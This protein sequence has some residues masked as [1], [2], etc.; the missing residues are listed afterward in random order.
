ME[1]K[2]ED[3]ILIKPTDWLADVDEIP[4]GKE[5]RSR[6]RLFIE[7]Y[8]PFELNEVGEA[9]YYVGNRVPYH[10][11]TTGCETFLVD[12]GAIEIFSRSRKAVA[13][14]GDIVHIQPYTPHAIRSLEDDSIW[15]AF[16]QGHSLV[17]NMIAMSKF[18]ETYPELAASPDFRQTMPQNSKSVWYD[19]ILPE[20]VDVPVSEFTEIRT[21]EDALAEFN[22]DK[23]NL[24]LKVGRWETDGAKEVWQLTMKSGCNFSWAPHNSFPF[25]FDIYDGAVE[26]RLD[27]KDPMIANTRDLLHIPKFL[28]GSLKALKDTVLLDMGC[29]GSC[30]RYLD[31]INWFR[32]NE[33]EK[34]KNPEFLDQLM[35]KYNYFIQFAF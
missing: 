26:V 9:N 27:G 32:A 8:G 33:P 18:R 31:E 23:L 11:H 13:R 29:Q 17:P 34:L 28:G 14:K 6:C 1:M 25:V 12:N 30:M 5:P 16:H 10:E 2:N 20:C 19:Y 21:P 15:R 22:F 24:K 35:R 4:D 3:R 7:P